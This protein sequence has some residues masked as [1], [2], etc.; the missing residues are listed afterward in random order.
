[1]KSFKSYQHQRIL[2]SD[3]TIANGDYII[4][5][6]I[7]VRI[8]DGFLNDVEGD[9]GS[10]L[11]AIATADGSHIEHWKEGVLH[12]ENEPAVI[13]NIDNYEEWWLD[14]KQVLPQQK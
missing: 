5:E 6:E 3:K 9:D 14:G 4:D 13:D 11:P 10:L 12:C 7:T 8:K 1:M 2:L